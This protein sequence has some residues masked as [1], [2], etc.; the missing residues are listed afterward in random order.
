MGLLTKEVEVGLSGE[1]IKWFENLGYIIPREIDKCGRNCVKKGTTIIVNVGDL[2][3][4]SN[5]MVEVQ[6]DNSSCNKIL[7][8]MQLNT[9]NKYIKDGV[10][11]CKTCALELYG[12]KNSMQTKLINSISFK[13]WCLDNNRQDVLD[14]W[15]Y[16]LNNCLPNEISY[17]SNKKYYFQCP[18]GIHKS[19][20]KNISNFTKRNS[21][22]TC[23][24]CNSFAQWGID[25][26]CKDF[27][28][29]YWD[30]DKNILD[31]WEI[32][33]A[34]S[35]S[36][37]YIICQEKDYHE[38]YLIACASFSVQR[39]RC[40]YCTSKKIHK[41][42]SLGTLY[43][44]ALALWSDKNKKSPYEYTTHTH[45]QVYWKCENG[46]HKDY[47]RGV[48][49]SNRYNFRCPECDFS[50]GEERISNNLINSDWIQ[51]SQ[52]EFDK[53]INKY[54][55]KYFIP[56]KEF[57][58][59]VGL[60]GGL[61]SY[62]FYLPKYNLLIEYQGEYHDG[63]VKNQTKEDFEKQVEHDRRK[64]EYTQQ[65]GYNFLEIWYKDFDN[66]ESILAKELNVI[67]DFNISI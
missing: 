9:Y 1:N 64:K 25:N 31:P 39:S 20:L 5:A 67:K 30:Y 38:N 54:N 26:I 12:Y 62:D 4:N 24:Q 50:K 40:P 43:P 3:S 44:K 56:Q 28:E 19:E 41:L 42:D 16:V 23:N 35:S 13:Q 45:Q 47:L 32:S 27:L 58:G 14:R 6:C 52:E 63:T 57:E 33:Y 60:G 29:K 7:K 10:Y 49:G 2:K 15:D 17:S 18:R 34:N 53:I 46:K 8:K 59:L 65:N 51:I 48:D 21:I 11:Y 37:V 61:L 22:I 36:K 66:I 55:N